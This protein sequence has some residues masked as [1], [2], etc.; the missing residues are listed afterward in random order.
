MI[1]L[2]L[3]LDRLED[4]MALIDE[5]QRYFVAGLEELQAAPRPSCATR[6]E[7]SSNMSSLAS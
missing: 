1:D 5:I 4:D 3:L 6:A 7:V 2:D